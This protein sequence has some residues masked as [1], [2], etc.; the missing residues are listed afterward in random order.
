MPTS[1]KNNLARALRKA[2]AATGLSQED[3]G[4]VSGRTYISQLER[5][6]R[7]ATLTKVDEL[8]SV[9]GVHPTALLLLAYLPERPSKDAAERL[10]A[11]AREDLQR[12][13]SVQTVG[14]VKAQP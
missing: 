5:R 9:I 8:A 11:T 13:L 14:T 2:R 3:F 6:E 12:L 7:H 10:L 4:S 1:P